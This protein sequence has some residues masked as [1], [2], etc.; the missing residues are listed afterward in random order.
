[1]VVFFGEVL[2]VQVYFLDEVIW[3]AFPTYFMEYTI[4]KIN[5]CRVVV[6]RLVGLLDKGRT[7]EGRPFGLMEEFGL[8]GGTFEFFPGFDFQD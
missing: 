8:K 7:A 5:F 3:E 6:G 1:M 4:V 2:V